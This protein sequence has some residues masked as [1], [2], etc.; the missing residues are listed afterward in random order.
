M[1]K[2][3]YLQHKETIHNFIWRALQVFGKQGI[4]FLIFI[5]CAKLLVPYDFGIYNYALAIICFLIMFGDFGI[6]TATSKYVAEYNLK[7]KKK[8]KSV[9]FNTGI[10][11]LGL[12]LIITILTLIIG[13]FYLKDKYA[14]I[15]YLLPLI[16]LAPMTSLYDGIYRGLKKFKQLA[17]ISTV[18]GFISIFFVYLLI[19][20]YGLIGALVSQNIFY[21]ILLIGLGL[22]YRDFNFKFNKQ[23]IKEIGSYSFN[24]GI[25]VVGY[26]LFSRLDILILGHYGYINEIAVY[27]LLNKI[28]LVLL[29]PFAILGQVIAPNYTVLYAERKYG[30]IHR[31]FKIYK[32]YLIIISSLFT[33]FLFWAIP[34]IINLFFIEYSTT[35][36]L[37]IFYPTLLIYSVN[38]FNSPINAGMIVATGHARFMAHLNIFI[39]ITNVFISLLLLQFMGFI[40][41]IYATLIMNLVGTVILQFYYHNKIKRLRNEN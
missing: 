31:K 15:L 29:V 6:S 18:I 37:L 23:V 16:F 7:D 4:T 10:I 35:S 34:K 41:V 11:V 1:L 25:A 36:F 14:Y 2:N 19:N 9:L 32:K 20:Q 26:Y 17:I 28:F 12:T 21:L 40:G 3:K 13:P 5:L 27:E 30:L 33:L 24:F 8:L 38:F 39:A 22:G